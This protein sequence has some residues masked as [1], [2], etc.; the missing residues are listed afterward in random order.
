[1]PYAVDRLTSDGLYNIVTLGR[2]C[3]EKLLDDFGGSYPLAIAAYNARAGPC[4]RM[5]LPW[6]YGDPRGKQIRHG[7]LDQG[8]PASPRRDFYVQ[9]VLESVQMRYRE[10]RTPAIPPP[11]PSPPIW[12]GKFNVVRRKARTPTFGAQDG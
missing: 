2:A 6:E 12:R 4:P 1:M 11:F 7:R 5:A 9:R 10:A 8:D 3:V